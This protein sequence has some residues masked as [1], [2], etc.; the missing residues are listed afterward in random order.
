MFQLEAYPVRVNIRHKTSPCSWICEMWAL[1]RPSSVLEEVLSWIV[2]PPKPRMDVYTWK[3]DWCM[4]LFH[5]LEP[6][7]IKRCRLGLDLHMYWSSSMP[8]PRSMPPFLR[9][10]AFSNKKKA[11]SCRVCLLHASSQNVFLPK[12]VPH[13]NVPL[14]RRM[15]APIKHTRQFVENIAPQIIHMMPIHQEII[16]HQ[17]FSRTHHSKLVMCW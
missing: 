13:K 4:Q 14:S 11:F 16:T 6:V 12:S 17:D 9:E 15:S 10:H 7:Y 1:A 3:R 2:H 8:T 5:P